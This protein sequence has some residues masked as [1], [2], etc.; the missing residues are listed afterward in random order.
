MSSQSI[1]RMDSYAPHYDAAEI[2]MLAAGV[3]FVV[4]IPF[5]L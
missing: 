5:L 3:V 4:V 2:L 1:R